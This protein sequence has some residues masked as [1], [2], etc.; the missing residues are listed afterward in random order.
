MIVLIDISET[1][2]FFSLEI[3]RLNKRQLSATEYKKYIAYLV[4]HIFKHQNNPGYLY[5][6]S[7]RHLIELGFSEQEA[8]SLDVNT[9]RFLLLDI[10]KGLSNFTFNREDVELLENHLLDKLT[11]KIK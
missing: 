7:V 4:N 6:A 8:L 3:Q 9:F 5:T 2:A 11:L 1:R 10:T